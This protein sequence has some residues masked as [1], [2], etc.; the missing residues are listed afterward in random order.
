MNIEYDK[1]FK[2]FDEQIN[3]LR[4]RG[5]IINDV[6]NAKIILS[7]STYYELINGYKN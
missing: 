1:P 2:S 5:L 7:T 4:S 3:I 6:E